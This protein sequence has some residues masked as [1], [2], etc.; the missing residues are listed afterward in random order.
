MLPSSLF[1]LF[2]FLLLVQ[3]GRKPKKG[4]QSS[5]TVTTAGPSSSASSSSASASASALSSLPASDVLPPPPSTTEVDDPDP[6]DSPIDLFDH[7]NLV[8][9]I[10]CQTK[11]RFE[12]L[13]QPDCFL[14][15]EQIHAPPQRGPGLSVPPTRGTSSFRFYGGRGHCEIYVIATHILSFGR[16]GVPTLWEP[17]EV[18]WIQI[19]IHVRLRV[20]LI[21]NACVAEPGASAAQLSA[22]HGGKGGASAIL[23]DGDRLG[24]R[25]LQSDRTPE[26]QQPPAAIQLEILMHDGQDLA[27]LRDQANRRA[28]GWDRGL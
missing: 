25:M 14:S 18:E 13:H 21:I 8:G 1:S 16:S 2:Y 23:M 10:V 15:A 28:E 17:T 26:G 19:W 9:N 3:A 27:R 20:D 6:T 12:V 24:S 4:R 22:V 7:R 5:S 11:P